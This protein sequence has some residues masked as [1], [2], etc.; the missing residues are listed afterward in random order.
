[1]VDCLD[2]ISFNDLLFLRR[3]SLYPEKKCIREAVGVQVIKMHNVSDLLER[4]D[5]YY[6]KILKS[7]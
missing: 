3:S 2:C 4:S 5:T 1:M 6:S 7:Q